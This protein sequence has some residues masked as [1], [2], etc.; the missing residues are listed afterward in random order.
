MQVCYLTDISLNINSFIL[1]CVFAKFGFTLTTSEQFVTPTKH[2][3]SAE[4]A[5]ACKGSNCSL[6]SFS[7]QLKREIPVCNLFNPDITFKDVQQQLSSNPL[8]AWGTGGPCE[9]Y[10][11]NVVLPNKVPHN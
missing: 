2:G 3:S 10:K 5:T 1:E 7:G 8:A 4:C 11:G 9:L 6:W